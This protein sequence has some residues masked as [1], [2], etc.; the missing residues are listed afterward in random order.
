MRRLTCLDGLR[1]ALINNW[2]FTLT[3]DVALLVAIGALFL[4]GGAYL[5]SRIEA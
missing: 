4:S 5:F 1:G 3:V 2:Y